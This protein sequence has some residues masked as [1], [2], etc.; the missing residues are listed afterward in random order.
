MLEI[1]QPI[2]LRN[3]LLILIIRLNIVLETFMQGNFPPIN[4]TLPK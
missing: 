3:H 2:A 4:Y 1:V